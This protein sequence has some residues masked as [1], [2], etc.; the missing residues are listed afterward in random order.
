MD[1]LSIQRPRAE[2]LEET[3]NKTINKSKPAHGWIS[4]L[5]IPRFGDPPVST[6]VDLDPV[7]PTDMD[8][9]IHE[10]IEY[11]NNPR[12][13][14]NEK[15]SEIE[16]LIRQRGFTSTLAVTRRPGRKNYIP[17]QGGNTTLSCVKK[18][19]HET[20]NPD[21]EIIHCR[22]HPWVSEFETRIKHLIENDVRGA[23]IWIDR[24][25]AVMDAWGDVKQDSGAE[26]V[27]QSQLSD[28]LRANGYI[29]DQTTISRMQY[30]VESLYPFMPLALDGGLGVKPV[31][32]V[33]KLEKAFK[34]YL[35][36]SGIDDESALC[37]AAEWF[38]TL[39]AL[40][41]NNESWKIDPVLEA[42]VDKAAALTEASPI[43]VRLEIEA[44]LAGGQSA[45]DAISKNLDASVAERTEIPIL[46]TP[47]EGDVNVGVPGISSGEDEAKAT[48]PFENDSTR[49]FKPNDELE[50]PEGNLK[51][52]HERSPVDPERV[53]TVLS[54]NVNAQDGESASSFNTERCND[55]SQVQSLVASSTV[56]V[57]QLATSVE[58][59]TQAVGLDECVINTE[60]DNRYGF[61][62]DLPLEPIDLATNDVAERQKVIVWWLLCGL[63]GQFENDE[64]TLQSQLPE[65]SRLYQL[66]ESLPPTERKSALNTLCF[67]YVGS[68]SAGT[69][70]RDL[71]LALGDEA[72]TLLINIIRGVRQ[73]KGSA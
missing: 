60:S 65:Y 38:N 40:H 9:S 29:V 19:H 71:L 47:Y 44:L 12:R 4:N 57:S 7:K 34:D 42:V 27:S 54:E 46:T 53:T 17:I 3:M 66:L 45:L 37:V 59:L 61:I 70:S 49:Y 21:L 6:A 73:L 72:F 28:T 31:I 55:V 1:C 5:G 24:A 23:L 25:Q 56:N 39:L 69:I 33:R 22:F 68:V 41:D 58:L 43:N 16:N 51:T 36:H 18:V 8:L 64:S 62:M 10:I 32:R 20:Q 14:V 26:K 50:N 30:T 11:E 2:I 35:L 15:I 63:C 52:T 48:E 67:E 13:A